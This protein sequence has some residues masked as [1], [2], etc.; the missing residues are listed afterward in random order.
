MKATKLVEKFQNLILA[1]GDFD[2]F[3]RETGAPV[4]DVIFS[5]EE[6]EPNLDAEPW[7]ELVLKHESE[8]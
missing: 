2:V 5:D 6:N 3:E 1:H 4:S 7:F 8:S